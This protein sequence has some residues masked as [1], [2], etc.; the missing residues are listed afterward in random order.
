MKSFKSLSL[1][2]ILI[3]AGSFALLSDGCK[4]DEGG[5]T[6]GGGGNVVPIT[7]DL[8]PLVAGRSFVYTGYAISTGG[9]A[10]PDSPVVYST[11]W[12]LAGPGPFPGSTIIVDSTTL[13]HPLAGVIRV[14]KLLFIRKDTTTGDFDFL[15]TLGP[16]YRAFGISSTDTLRWFTVAKPSAGASGTWTAFDSTFSSPA[17]DV[18][19]EIKGEMLG[20]VS[21]TDSSSSHQAWSTYKTRTYRNIYVSGNPVVTNSTTSQLWLAV[22]VGPVQV[23]IAQDTENLGHFRVMTSKSF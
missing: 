15:Q 8:F 1:F 12:L 4:K 22:D 13:R 14:G 10:L 18:R 2:A 19:L 9:S 21:V 5:T 23:H 3:A 16:F 17:G 7:D 11:T 20:T 6:G